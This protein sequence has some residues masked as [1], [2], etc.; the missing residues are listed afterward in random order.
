MLLDAL[1]PR[2]MTVA[3]S[4]SWRVSYGAGLPTVESLQ[5]VLCPHEG[6]VA[7]AYRPAP[8]RSWC[9]YQ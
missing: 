5:D 9:V 7:V 3:C 1:R 4:T 8:W 6:V 2:G